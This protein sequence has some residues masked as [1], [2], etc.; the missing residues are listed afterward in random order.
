MRAVIL[1]CAAAG[2]GAFAGPRG[3]CAGARPLLAGFGKAEKKEKAVQIK[4]GPK[5]MDKQWDRYFA[6]AEAGGVTKEVWLT[7]PGGDKPLPLGFV[8]CAAGGDVAEALA[9]QK[10]LALWCAE[11]LHPRL[12]PAL[13]GKA[14]K[15]GEVKLELAYCDV[16]P[17]SDE[18][19]QKELDAGSPIVEGKPP[20]G[21]LTPL[22]KTRAPPDLADAKVGFMPFKSP[23]DAGQAS[24]APTREKSSAAKGAAGRGGGGGGPQRGGAG[25]Q[26]GG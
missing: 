20:G 7:T 13:R 24:A 4:G 18:D 19:K 26:R 3:A 21:P 25:A 1:L 12:A 15:D 11:G 9:L 8:A 23:V 16:A 2:A 5:P 22:G 14:L 10:T 6:L 17:I